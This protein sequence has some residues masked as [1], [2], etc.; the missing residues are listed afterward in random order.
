MSWKG[1]YYKRKNGEKVLRKKNIATINH[2][3]NLRNAI[4][5]EMC[6]V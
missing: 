3:D 6:E 4:P 5:C 1:K 2:A